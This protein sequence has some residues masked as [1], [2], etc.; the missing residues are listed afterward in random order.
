MNLDVLGDLRA[1]RS[2]RTNQTVSSSATR[3]LAKLDHLESITDE[4]YEITDADLKLLARSPKLRTLVLGS[5]H[6]TAAALPSLAQIKSLRELYVTEK[7]RI[8]AD[9][10]AQ[11]GKTSLTECRISRFRPPYTIFYQPPDDR[12]PGAAMRSFAAPPLPRP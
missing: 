6:V 4:L 5:E 7:V 8:R 2:L 3:A 12:T 10:L 9:Q 1:L 11:L